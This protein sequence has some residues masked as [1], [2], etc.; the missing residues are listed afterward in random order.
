MLIEMTRELDTQPEYNPANDP[1]IALADRVAAEAH[2]N[3]LYGNDDPYINHCRRVAARVFRAGGSIVQIAAA[4]LHDT[5]EDTGHT[6]ET[7]RVAGV[8]EPVIRIV[9]VMSRKIGPNGKEPYHAGLIARC[10]ADA[11]AR[12]PKREDVTENRSCLP[13]NKTP[14]EARGLM[15]RYNRALEML[16][17]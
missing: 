15:K 10:A 12:L 2:A 17:D 16:R 6:P 13:G 9:M 8:P 4:L 7:L 3:Q 1:V 5:I 11:E 14:E